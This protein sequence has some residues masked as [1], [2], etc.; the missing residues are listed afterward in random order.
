MMR[1]RLGT[2][3]EAEVWASVGALFNQTGDLVHSTDGGNT[4]E[5]FPV[6]PT[7]TLNAV[8]FLDVQYGWAARTGFFHTTDGGATWVKDN[9]WCAIYGLFFEGETS[10]NT[11]EIRAAL[12][13]ND[14]RVGASLASLGRA[15]LCLQYVSKENPAGPP[16][17]M[18]TARV[19]PPDR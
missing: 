9:N 3:N 13:V 19:G 12:N 14:P 15:H 8:F 10:A 7:E 5:V 2:R 17:T 16:R 11:G 6:N 1:A 4:W 18:H